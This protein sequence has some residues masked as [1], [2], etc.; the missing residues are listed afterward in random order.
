MSLARCARSC[1]SLRTQS[2]FPTARNRQPCCGCRCS[3]ALARS[4]FGVARAV[5]SLLLLVAYPVPIPDRSQLAAVLWL[6]LLADARFC[7]P[8]QQPNVAGAAFDS[9][10]ASAV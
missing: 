1:S 6:P 5:R 2:L 8:L 10:L 3:L 4:L 7:L 9:D